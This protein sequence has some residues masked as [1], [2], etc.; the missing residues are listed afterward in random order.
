[1]KYSS[2]NDE[3]VLTLLKSGF[4]HMDLDKPD[5]YYSSPSNSKML[6]EESTEDYIFDFEIFISRIIDVSPEDAEKLQDNLS[7]AIA[8]KDITFESIYPYRRPK[9]GEVIWVKTFCDIEYV[10]GIAKSV[11][12]IN[13]DITKEHISTVAL[14]KTKD[15]LKRAESNLVNLFESSL[16]AIMLVDVQTNKFITLNKAARVMYCIPDDLDVS[17]LQASNLSADYQEDGIMSMDKAAEF[18]RK[19]F[20]QGGVKSE[21][22]A[23]RYDGTNFYAQLSISPS[24]FEGRNVVSIISRDITDIKKNE[25]QTTLI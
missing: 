15:K 24:V 13:K 22:R 2:K 9:D 1:M 17:T 12:G 20:E 6:G 16:D 7:R 25:K 23:K 21:W 14:D 11:F 19:A 3:E 4:W 8:K 10:E 18:A 5:T